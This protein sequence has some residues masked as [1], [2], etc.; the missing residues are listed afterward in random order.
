MR[1]GAIAV[2]GQHFDDPAFADL[3]MP[4][5]LHHQ[6]KLGLQGRQAADAL[7]D[8]HESGLCDRVRGGAWLRW[9]VLEGEERADGSHLKANI[10]AGGVMILMGVAMV[11]GTLTTFSYWLLQTFP[12]FGRIG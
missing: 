11:T 12:V 10:I 3:P 2:V 6:L 1:V 4:A 7:L 8:L 9:V 5:P